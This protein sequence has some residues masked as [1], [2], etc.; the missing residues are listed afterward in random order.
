MGHFPKKQNTL[1]IEGIR[2]TLFSKLIEN[3]YGAQIRCRS[4]EIPRH[5]ELARNK[6]K[7]Q[8]T[9]VDMHL[10]ICAK[11]ISNRTVFCLSIDFI[12]IA[13]GFFWTC[14]VMNAIEYCSWY[15]T[16]TK[17]IS[18]FSNVFI[19]QSYHSIFIKFWEVI[20]LYEKN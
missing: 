10:H 8:Q 7:S 5:N 18:W 20:D 14:N 2:K 16:N 3:Y 13:I 12:C 9:N 6:C 1:C 19:K 17:N 4:D 15:Q 11:N